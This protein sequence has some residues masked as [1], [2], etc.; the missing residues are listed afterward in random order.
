MAFTGFGSPFGTI[1]ISSMRQ[2]SSVVGSFNILRI[3][4]SSVA[5]NTT[6]YTPFFPVTL[7]TTT[8]VHLQKHKIKDKI[9]CLMTKPTKWLCAQWRLRSAWA[10]AQSDQSSLSAWRKRRSL[11]T[12]WAHSKDSDQNGR[13]SSLGA[14]SFC[15]F[16]DEA[17]QILIH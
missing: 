10:S 5:I 15:M 17:V 8:W 12:H 13:M 11:A 1:L 4:P 14:Q 6:L 9:N 7:S 3:L 16:C 2:V